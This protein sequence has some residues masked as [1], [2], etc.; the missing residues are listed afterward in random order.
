MGVWGRGVW[1]HGDE[2]L[3]KGMGGGFDEG[4]SGF[5]GGDKWGFI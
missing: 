4:G 3:M 5:D 1:G 2:G